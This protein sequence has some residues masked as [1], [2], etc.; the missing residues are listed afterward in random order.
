MTEARFKSF[1]DEKRRVE[2]RVYFLFI[3]YPSFT[4]LKRNVLVFTQTYKLHLGR[5]F[6]FPT[7][8]G[9]TVARAAATGATFK[10]PI[11][12]FGAVDSQQHLL[13]CSEKS[14]NDCFSSDSGGNTSQLFSPK[15]SCGPESSLQ[16]CLTSSVPASTLLPI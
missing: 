1:C 5:R 4:M 11:F 10:L 9:P 8:S 12:V 13:R 15:V 6:G 7:S 3:F 16:K 14:L 2:H